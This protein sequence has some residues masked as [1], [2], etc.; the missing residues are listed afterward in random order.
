MWAIC[1]ALFYLASSQS[2]GRDLC[3]HESTSLVQTIT[4]VEKRG[5]RPS[6]SSSSV[7]HRIASQRHRRPVHLIQNS[8]DSGRLQKLQLKEITEMPSAITPNESC[9][10]HTQASYITNYLI[11]VVCLAFF[12]VTI[13]KGRVPYLTTHFLAFLAM[14]GLTF[15]F[16]GITTNL[17]NDIIRSGKTLGFHV[18]GRHSSWV[19]PWLCCN[20]VGGMLWASIIALGL[21]GLAGDPTPDAL[22]TGG[23]LGIVYFGYLVGALAGLYAVMNV[24]GGYYGDAGTGALSACLC[25]FAG[26]CNSF[27]LTTALCRRSGRPNGHILALVGMLL[28]SLGFTYMFVQ[29]Y[30][31]DTEEKRCPTFKDLSQDAIAHALVM[32]SIPCLSMSIWAKIQA[33]EQAVSE[34]RREAQVYEQDS[35]DRKMEA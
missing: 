24:L 28:L 19:I 14:V 5:H 12:I 16:A 26:L 22:P 11:F 15:G 30:F 29:D 17:Q 18:F 13:K 3:V 35:C 9:W 23:V 8:H 34:T 27:F 25:V 7:V 21:L 20:T 6:N 4:F 32:C 2:H 33:Y 10:D 31:L 1:V